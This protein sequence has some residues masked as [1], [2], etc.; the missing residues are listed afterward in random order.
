MRQALVYAAGAAI[1]PVPIASILLLFTTRKALANGLAFVAGW[2]AGVAAVVSAF[3]VLT[4]AVGLQRSD[5]VGLA[6]AELLLGSAFV[7]AAVVV[8]RRRHRRDERR[9]LWL[10]RVDGIT[11]SKSAGSGALL[12]GLNPKVAA[13]SLGAAL[14]LAEAN[15]TAPVELVTVVLYTLI[16]TLGVLVPLAAY[17]AA[18][19]PARASDTLRRF[20]GW[21]GR[22]EALALS[23]VG[24]L[25]GSVFLSSGVRGI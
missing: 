8:W 13:L 4:P 22:N 6:A 11:P 12:S 20:R 3:V 21:L 10:D 17:A 14:A 23:A 2:T 25:V 19:A 7:L 15:A 1:S 9:V 16:A 24:L 5:P 18:P